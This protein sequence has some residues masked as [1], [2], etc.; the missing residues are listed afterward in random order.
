MRCFGRC[1]WADY[2]Q[3]S[4]DA[5]SD[6]VTHC[7]ER[8]RELEEQLH[9][10]ERLQR[11]LLVVCRTTTSDVTMQLS[12]RSQ[13]ALRKDRAGMLRR[14][15]E[16]NRRCQ[17]M[18]QQIDLLRDKQSNQTMLQAMVQT[19]WAGE[20]D[21]MCEAEIGALVD[22]IELMRERNED[23]TQDLCESDDDVSDD[24]RLFRLPRRL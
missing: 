17:K 4:I 6:V 19:V 11:G 1:G 7:R 20:Q 13:A 22:D 8:Q 16:Y 18:Q 23:T 21:V 14:W 12:T 2:T 5:L 15:D 9:Q 24:E 3:R 10:C